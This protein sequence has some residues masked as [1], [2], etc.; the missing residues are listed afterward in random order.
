[1]VQLTEVLLRGEVNGALSTSQTLAHEIMGSNYLGI[2]EVTKHLRV[3]PRG[4]QLRTLGEVPFSEEVLTACKSSHVLIVVRPISIVGHWGR[5]SGRNLFAN[6]DSEGERFANSY[7]KMGWQLVCK[8][9]VAGS[10]SKTWG[11]QQDL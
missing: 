5:F 7:G 8:T 10:M 1:M 6:Q 2:Q 11:E 4:R 9:P 3:N